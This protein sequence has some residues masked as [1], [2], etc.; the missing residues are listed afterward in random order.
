MTAVRD[1]VRDA[2]VVEVVRTPV[3]RFG[4]ALAE[5]RPD[6][7]GAVVLEALVERSWAMAKPG[8]ARPRGDQTLHDTALGWRFVHPHMEEGGRSST[9]SEVGW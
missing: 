6:D 8:S 3:G 7:L 5:V 1:A 2:V 9:E 4:R